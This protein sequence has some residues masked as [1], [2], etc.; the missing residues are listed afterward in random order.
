MTTVDRSTESMTPVTLPTI[1]WDG[2]HGTTTAYTTRTPG[3]RILPTAGPF[4]EVTWTVMHHEGPQVC[5]GNLAD[6]E[7]YP[8]ALLIADALAAGA[9]WTRPATVIA[10]TVDNASIISLAASAS[11]AIADA[12]DEVMHAMTIALGD[13]A[14]VYEY[15]PDMH[16]GAIRCALAAGWTADALIRRLTG[17]LSAVDRWAAIRARLRRLPQPAPVAVRRP[18]WCRVCDAATRLRAIDGVLT[19]CATCYPRAHLPKTEK[20]RS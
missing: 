20:R 17:H 19:A 10:C 6:G 9:D 2:S 16:S 13:Q 11:R 3:L 4:G 18:E 8:E 1:R 12:A 5:R 14:R 7:T 15:R